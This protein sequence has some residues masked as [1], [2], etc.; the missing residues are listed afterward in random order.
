L[1]ASELGFAAGESFDEI[2][3]IHAEDEL[4]GVIR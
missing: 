3:R 2:I 4:G 1:A